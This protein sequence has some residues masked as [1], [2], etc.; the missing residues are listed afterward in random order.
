MPPYAGR[1]IDNKL[2]DCTIMKNIDLK[3]FSISPIKWKAEKIQ[4]IKSYDL[5][6][7]R[8]L[9]VIIMGHLSLLRQPITNFE[10]S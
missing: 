4:L 8:K 9:Y 3:Q 1:I 5:F 6:L 10:S 2:D 7:D